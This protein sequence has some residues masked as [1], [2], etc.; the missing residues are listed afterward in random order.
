MCNMEDFIANEEDR[1]IRGDVFVA[2][3]L[4]L[5]RSQA[6]RLFALGHVLV[7][8][9]VSKPGRMLQ[10]GDEVHVRA[11]PPEPPSLQP[12]PMDLEVLYED[13]HLLV[14][15]KPRG[16]VVHPAA[17]HHHGTLVHALLARVPAL[18][19]IGAPD[20]P[21]IVHRLDMDTSGLMVVAK[22]DAAHRSLQA[23]IQARKARRDYVAIVW[24]CPA[25]ETATIDAAI[26][27]HPSDRKKMAVLPAGAPGAKPA[28]TELAVLERLPPM[29]VVEA[30]LR[31]GRTHQIR[32]HCAYAGHPVVGDPLYGEHGRPSG[33]GVLTPAAEDALSA[34]RGQ[35]LHARHLSFGHPVDGRLMTFEAPLPDDMQRLLDAL[36][37]LTNGRKR[38][39]I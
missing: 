30:S 38:S 36:R 34:L 5:S 25:F 9:T 26:G 4:Q 19:S 16:L 22:S 10:P 8:G 29:S 2:R 35:A 6:A 14:L 3:R 18:S 39:T 20:R 17:G 28:V 7:N 11:E 32:V 27:R 23:Q 13:E 31:T 37:K 24:G 1:G 21:G 15:D 33:S 12:E